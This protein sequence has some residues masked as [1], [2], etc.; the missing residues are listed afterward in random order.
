MVVRLLASY[1]S[2][3]LPKEN[4]LVLIS[5]ERLSKPQGHSAAGRI[6]YIEKCNDLVGS[7][8]RDHP[9]CSIVLQ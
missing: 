6:R 1:A 7:R 9:A 2:C 5:V 3:E 8:T 4:I